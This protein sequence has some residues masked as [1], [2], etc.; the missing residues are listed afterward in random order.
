MEGS[1]QKIEEDH[2]KSR[3]MTTGGLCHGIQ[4]IQEEG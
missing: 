3:M 1:Q 4:E 2:L